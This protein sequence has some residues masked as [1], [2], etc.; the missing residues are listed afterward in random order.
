MV[1]EHTLVGWQIVEIPEIQWGSELALAVG[2]AIYIDT[3]FHKLTCLKPL[4][5]DFNL[6]N[7]NTV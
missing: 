6:V 7:V 3:T 1:L 2:L 4:A 5:R